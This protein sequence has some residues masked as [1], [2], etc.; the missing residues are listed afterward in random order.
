MGGGQK[1]QISEADS[2]MAVTIS[3]QFYICR[4]PELNLL[5]L[6]T[7]WKWVGPTSVSVPGSGS[8]VDCALISHE[9]LTVGPL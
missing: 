1:R 6:E 9:S 5:C 3:L 4:F 7:A 8:Y 2:F